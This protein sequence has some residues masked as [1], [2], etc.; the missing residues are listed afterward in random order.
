MSIFR[1][2]QDERSEL[3]ACSQ[4]MIKETK[5]LSSA[6]SSSTQGSVSPYRRIF[7][8]SGLPANVSW[9]VNV[10]GVR[11]VSNTST[12]L[13]DDLSGQVNYSYDCVVTAQDGKNLYC[14]DGCSGTSLITNSS[15]SLS[16]LHVEGNKVKD[17]SGNTVT[18]KGVVVR[19]GGVPLEENAANEKRLTE[20]DYKYLAQQWNAQIIRFPVTP[21]YWRSNP[22]Y[23][24]RI[25]DSEVW[26]ANKYGMYAIIEWH[27]EGDI[28]HPGQGTNSGAAETNITETINFWATVAQ[29]YSGRS[30]VIYEIFNEPG[31]NITWRQWRPVAQAI[32][33]TIRIY[34]SNSLILIGGTSWSYN[35]QDIAANPVTGSNLVYA[36]HPYPAKCGANTKCWDAYFGNTAGKY[37][38][39]VTEWGYYTPDQTYKTSQGNFD[40]IET[41][42][43]GIDKTGYSNAL[44]KYLQEH[45]ITWTA[46][47]WDTTWCPV[48]ITSWNNYQ[49][50]EY[51]THVRNL[52]SQINPT[53]TYSPQ[54]KTN[55]LTTALEGYRIYGI[56]ASIA[57]LAIICIYLLLRNRSTGND[58]SSSRTA[59]S[60][61][62]A[63]LTAYTSTPCAA[64]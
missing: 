44:P 14:V 26:W 46:W 2:V 52:L 20:T 41:V 47:I 30:G 63:I 40:C 21:I 38:V 31:D 10:N 37:P 58:E 51:G 45:G 29:H 39:W 11:Y 9:G 48:M 56:G 34:D 18:L 5:I 43:S 64:A 4:Q 22:F 15:S 32:V 6:T 60:R 61:R 13:V 36:A 28:L 62:S 8:P 16:K 24:T 50:T 12:V 7:T 53:P 1:L 55:N 19:D 49:P 54:P 27:G 42:P 25:L 57:A 17:K 59:P 23:L 35:L 33:D 3:P